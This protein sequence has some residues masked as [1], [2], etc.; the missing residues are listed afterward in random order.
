MSN[1]QN[2][3]KYINNKNTKYSLDEIEIS[4][5]NTTHNDSLHKGKIL[6]KTNSKNYINEQNQKK[7]NYYLALNTIHKI[8]N[9]TFQELSLN[10]FSEINII[11]TKDKNISN[12]IKNPIKKEV[13]KVGNILKTIKTQEFKRPNMNLNNRNLFNIIN[14]IN[15]SVTEVDEDES[16]TIINETKNTKSI[17]NS[18]QKDNNK[19][20]NNN[21]ISNNK[22]KEKNIIKD[23]N[24]FSTT[25]SKNKLNKKVAK[26]NSI[27]NN[28]L[29]N[30]DIINDLEESIDIKIKDYNK[31]KEKNFSNNINPNQLINQYFEKDPKK[32]FGKNR[33]GIFNSRIF[34]SFDFRNLRK[35]SINYSIHEIKHSKKWS[36]VD[37]V[38]KNKTKTTTGKK[39]RKKYE[40]SELKSNKGIGNTIN[41]NNLRYYNSSKN[42]I[43]IREG[44]NEDYLN[45]LRYLTNENLAKNLMGRFNMCS[46]GIDDLFE[47]M[48][49]N[50]NEKS[51][52]DSNYEKEDLNNE[53]LEFSD[54]L[55]NESGNLKQNNNLASKELS[56]NNDTFII[57]INDNTYYDLENENVISSNKNKYKSEN[58]Q[59]RNSYVLNCNSNNINNI[60]RSNDNFCSPQKIKEFTLI[61]FDNSNNY[62]KRK[63]KLILEQNN[64]NLNDNSIE[65]RNKT[66][67]FVNLIPIEQDQNGFLDLSESPSYINTQSQHKLQNSSENNSLNN[68]IDNNNQSHQ[69][70]Y[71]SIY[72]IEFYQ[73]LLAAN[74][75]YKKVNFQNIFKNQPLINWE[76]RL[77][78]LLW[79]MRI[80]EEFA[81]K[82]DTY[83]YSCF[84]FDLYLYL[85]KEKIKNKNE[86]KLIGI[87]CISISA[88]IEEVQIPKLEEY[89][90][91]IN[92][93]TK[94]NKIEDII[95]TE[96]KICRALGWKL[97]PMTISSWLNWYTCQWDLFVNSIDDIKEKLLL[98]TNDDNIL[99]F[100]K[101]NEVSYYNYRRIYQ[102]IDLIA[103]D[104]HS[105]KY[106]IRYLVAASFLVSICLHYNLEYD[107]NKKI[108][109]KKNNL[110]NSDKKDIGKALLNVY[111]QFIE[112]SFDYSFE[113][114]KL[115]ECISYVYK[116]INFKF[117]YEIPLIFQI[118]QDHLNDYTY[119]DF[120]SYQTT[121]EN[122]Y[123]YFK[124]MQKK[125]AKKT[126]NK[127]SIKINKK[128]PINKKNNKSQSSFK[129]QSSTLKT[130]KSFSSRKSSSTKDNSKN[131]ISNI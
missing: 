79:M 43:Y 70:Q 61:P 100:K 13:I 27:G 35:N 19:K 120:I 96:K 118:E 102:L 7:V 41:K 126:K 125:E 18:I 122:I 87:T 89:A 6:T 75:S 12:Y 2:S 59:R 112:Q 121:S 107:S 83:H 98:I 32:F 25:I 104:F 116:F 78:T 9:D 80:C 95:N 58:K 22:Y 26:N 99:F 57:K 94:M 28:L 92:D 34:K 106:E 128:L 1:F 68:I 77:N 124:D 45:N 130:R 47:N 86:L 14:R 110:K 73:N 8:T 111:T 82:R 105:Y 29:Y 31:N 131:K 88:K 60:N 54:F 113:D 38:L 10:E 123:Q 36:N 23:Y 65:K 85:S 119:E 108:F 30:L 115:N 129:K 48:T 67:N 15:H 103:L 24:N 101:Q 63:S 44:K 21:T 81:F 72:D 33:N 52:N 5:N 71:Y 50:I 69:Q 55:S 93:C 49:F 76:E 16:S 42:E 39:L 4:E 11:N 46:Q 114:K 56:N 97:I 37:I 66:Q 74:N 64:N 53:K 20:I 127:K 51:K 91:S 40:R 84:Y 109:K 117:T 90:E 3:N 17:V 62:K